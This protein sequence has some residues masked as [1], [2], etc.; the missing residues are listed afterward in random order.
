MVGYDK[1]IN[2]IS[3]L[4]CSK[5]GINLKRRDRGKIRNIIDNR[6]SINNNKSLED[7]YEFFITSKEEFNS[8]IEEIV[9]NETKFM[10][11]VSHFDYLKNEYFPQLIENVS[12]SIVKRI[13]ILSLGCSYGQESYSI[14]F[15]L[16]EL[17]IPQ[18]IN[19]SIIGVDISNFAIKKAESGIYKSF[20]MRGLNSYFKN[21]YFKKLEND[22][23]EVV[24]DIKNMVEF[25]KL[26]IME[27]SFEIKLNLKF[28]IIFFKN[29]V[30]YFDSTI[31]SAVIKKVE[32]ILKRD[33]L[34]ILSPSETNMSIIKGENFEEIF[35]K[36]AII[37]KKL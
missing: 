22:S 5:T 26:N 31:V 25:Q 28:D 35:Y 4:I 20:E 14:G 13:R 18:D 37:Y 32:N 17:D 1:I 8:F 9:I 27:P 34:L 29:V 24:N 16:N 6:I 36:N 15:I 33:S 23:Y 19:V 11:D 2:D 30:F 10:R 7:Y 21:K 12:N 3:V